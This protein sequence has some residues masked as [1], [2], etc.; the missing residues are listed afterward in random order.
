[1]VIAGTKMSKRS[2]GLMSKAKRMAGM[3]KFLEEKKKLYA[4]PF[5]VNALRNDPIL[6][7]IILSDV[8]IEKLNSN[9]KFNAYSGARLTLDQRKRKNFIRA[10]ARHLKY[11]GFTYDI[12]SSLVQSWRTGKWKPQTH[13]KSHVF[14]FFTEFHRIWYRNGKKRVPRSLKLDAETLAW[15]FM[16]DGT[17]G[18]KKSHGEVNKRALKLATNDIHHDDIKLLIRKIKKLGIKE[19]Y[20]VKDN[21]ATLIQI[22]ASHAVGDF[23]R[24]VKPFVTREF[25]Y[26]LK[27]PLER[28][29]K[30]YTESIWQ[31]KLKKE[32]DPEIKKLIR[33]L[34][35]VD[36]K[37]YPKKYRSL[38]KWIW[39]LQNLEERRAYDREYKREESKRKSK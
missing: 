8:H 2:K 25:K 38:Y 35:K 1:M 26:K 19:V 15:W 13:L 16:G 3:K 36:K 37:K 27:M 17:N 21:D 22:G 32:K 5:L 4:D 18:E 29:N 20:P 6:N 9:R 30:E 10:V 7:G 31:K 33:T 12:S 14:M 11:L 34:M 24:L 28:S 23:L 39:R